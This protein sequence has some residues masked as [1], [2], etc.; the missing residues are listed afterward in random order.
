[1]PLRDDIERD[2]YD[3]SVLHPATLGESSCQDEVYGIPR[4]MDVRAHYINLDH[5]N[6]IGVVNTFFPLW[7]R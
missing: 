4:G 2:G 3:T 1:M 6:K 7:S 5:L